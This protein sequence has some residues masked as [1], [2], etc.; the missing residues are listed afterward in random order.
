MRWDRRLTVTIA[1]VGAAI[2]L[3][4]CST[5]GAINNLLNGVVG[6]AAGA[7]NKTLNTAASVPGKAL[8]PSTYSD[9]AK[10]ARRQ[11]RSY[12]ESTTAPRTSARNYD[13]QNNASNSTRKHRGR[14]AAT[15]FGG[16]PKRNFR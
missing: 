2:A 6:T 7:A 4:G 5:L 12:S 15:M 11:P 13:A 3:Q 14:S 8:T 10:K 16:G 9:L 1:V